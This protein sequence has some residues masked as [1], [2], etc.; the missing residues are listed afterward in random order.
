MTLF[1]QRVFA[2]V[3]VLCILGW[4]IILDYLGGPYLLHKC[5]YMREVEG[6]LTHTESE[7]GVMSHKPR[8]ADSH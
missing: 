5:P 7:T 8:N 6:D 2:D 4:E 1:G 3:I